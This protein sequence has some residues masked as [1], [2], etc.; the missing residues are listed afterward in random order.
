MRVLD[1]LLIGGGVVVVVVPLAAGEEACFDLVLRDSR[2]DGWNGATYAILTSEGRAVVTNGT[3]V[4][5]SEQTDTICVA[6]GCLS[7]EVASGGVSDSE[8]SWTLGGVLSGGAPEPGRDFLLREAGTVVANGSCTT[9]APT[10][11]MTRASCDF[12]DE[13]DDT[14]GWTTDGDYQWTRHAGETPSSKTGPS[15]WWGYY[16][17]VESSGSNS[18]NKGPFL[19]TSPPLAY[20]ETFYLIFSYHMYGEAMG[21]LEVE[22]LDNASWV[23]LGWIKTGDQGNLWHHSGSLEL[24]PTT[25][26]VRFV[27]YTGSSYTSDA[28]IDNV[29]FVEYAPSSA[30]TT[31]RVPTPAPSCPNAMITPERFRLTR[32]T[33]QVAH[34]GTYERDGSLSCECQPVFACLDCAETASLYY[35]SGS[36]VV[37]SST[38]CGSAN[39]T[40]YIKGDDALLSPFDFVR[41]WYELNGTE[42][43]ANFDI[44]VEYYV[45]ISGASAQTLREG[46]YERIGDCDERPYFIC[47]DCISSDT[48]YMFYYG[49]EDAW[50]VGDYGCDVNWGGFWVY[51]TA[52]NPLQI[53]ATWDEWQGYGWVANDAIQ[54]TSDNDA[55]TLAPT[56]APPTSTPIP[57]SKPST[58]AP[59]ATAAPS[60]SLLPSPL[61][62]ASPTLRSFLALSCSF[63]EQDICGWTTDGEEY[64]WARHS[65]ASP[66]IDTGPSTSWGYYMYIETAWRYPNHGPFVLT[67]PRF[68]IDESLDVVYLQFYYH[69]FGVALGNVGN[70]TLEYSPDGTSWFPQGWTR[71]GYQGVEWLP[72]TSLALPSTARVVRFVAY[73]GSSASGDIAIDNIT[74]ASY[75][76]TSTPTST[77]APTQPCFDLVML[78]SSSSDGWNGA[79]YKISFLPDEKLVAIGTMDNDELI[80][81]ETICVH[82]ISSCFLIQVSSA[83]SSSVEIFWILGGGVSS[84]GAPELGK[85]FYVTSSG[86]IIEAACTASPTEAPSSSFAPSATPAPSLTPI[87]T[88]PPSSAISSHEAFVTAVAAAGQSSENPEIIEVEGTIE[89]EDEIM[90][91]NKKIQVT[92][93]NGKA[94]F[95]GGHRVRLFALEDNAVLSLSNVVLTNGNVFSFFEYGGCV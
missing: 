59:S 92:G 26:A 38:G 88:L 84:G 20:D 86:D 31:T 69:M 29:T 70:L 66:S 40:M 28:A 3:L 35:D 90:I 56:T 60:L 77:R 5:G 48:Q 16:M 25:R 36:W 93:V 33:Y 19:L 53:A 76:P 12:D 34:A 41:E 21:N 14:C 55:V 64:Q 50:L 67:S 57:T 74:L 51:D 1:L 18:P 49:A 62:S 63:E 61:P 80:Q 72:S 22:Y 10:I 82:N 91:R 42:F 7:I 23:P 85:E 39:V 37:S 73:T 32:A 46:S 4:D 87:P 78:T 89:F 30:P 58:A 2:G 71:T 45:R 83:D 13:R 24:P 8:V 95:D 54:V 52:A 44:T 17:F 68:E 43:V 47:V 6:P 65:G 94:V 75:S 79:E 27:A 9:L 15:T 81:T 11:L